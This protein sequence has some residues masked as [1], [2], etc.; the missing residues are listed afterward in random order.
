MKKSG[1]EVLITVDGKRATEY[2]VEEGDVVSCYIAS[3]AGKVNH[4]YP[5]LTK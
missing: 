2:A 3:E 4:N 5:E 1:V